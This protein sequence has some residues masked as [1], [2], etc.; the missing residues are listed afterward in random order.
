MTQAIT[1]LLVDPLTASVQEVQMG[2]YIPTIILELI[3]YTAT[4]CD[5]ACL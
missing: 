3:L 5:H 2:S 4:E 1:I